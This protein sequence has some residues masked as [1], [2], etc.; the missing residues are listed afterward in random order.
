MFD[1]SVGPSQVQ[2]GSDPPD[3]P[4]YTAAVP[5]SDS[6]SRQPGP[7]AN[8]DGLLALGAAISRGTVGP[9]T[10]S[11]RRRRAR[12]RRRIWVRRGVF[13]AL[14]LVIV[15]ILAVVADYFYLGSLLNHTNVD[16]IQP[17]DGPAL[18]ILLVGST[19]RCA[20]KVQSKQY[21]EC[22]DGVNGVNSD[23]VMIAHL[24]NGKASLLSIPRDLF[25]PNAR[26]C[27]A[28]FPC[29]DGPNS[30]KI[31]AALF[32]GPSQLA[33]AIEEDFGIK[34]NHFIELNFATF[35][36]VVSSIGG[37]NMYFPMRVY[38]AE[39]S[40]NIERPGCYHLN[41]T[42]ALQVVRARHL[43]IGYP[44]A[45]NNPINWPQE[46]QS[47]LAR[48]RRT[49]EFLRIVATKIS[50]MGIGNLAEDQSLATKILPNLTV[51][52]GFGESQMVSLAAAYAGTNI[53]TVPQYTYP[54]VLNQADPQN[55]DSYQ[56]QGGLY[57]DVEFPVQPGGWLAVD[58]LF[59]AK[60]DQSPWDDTTLPAAGSFPMSVENGTSIPNQAATTAEQLRAK[61]FRITATGD[62]TPTGPTSETVVWYGG[63]APPKNGTWKDAARIDAVRVMTELEGPVILGYD[64]TQ[65]TPGDEVTVL[66][67]TALSV[68]TTNWTAPTTTT[69]TTTLHG[70][71]T[72]TTK[73]AKKPPVTATTVL[74]PPGIKTNP[75]LSAPSDLAQPL[76]PWD[77]R[78]CSAKMTV[79]T[80]DPGI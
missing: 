53:A 16:Y 38:D 77:P 47:D 63:P 15:L 59:G 35:A 30:N 69:T 12:S 74:D 14:G 29:T 48:I 54:V 19:N 60:P 62:R 34:I 71:T 42:K 43:Q 75:V 5:L 37:I 8:E 24:E 3:L 66:T 76:M 78:A 67:G 72:T 51:D 46:S 27:S 79:I 41:G 73:K 11:T 13:V 23:I 17:Q 6:P 52:N 56:Y 50:A 26:S 10:R 32:D 22:Q 61:G 28:E 57:G 25:V 20:Y 55:S 49:H 65:V 58:K 1:R 18:N 21:G 4:R 80:K 36:N 45:G 9:A 40:L 33:E 7:V 31:D 68:A 2:I 70:T 44:N 39:S 64:P